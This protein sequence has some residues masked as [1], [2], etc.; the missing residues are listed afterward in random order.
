VAAVVYAARFVPERWERLAAAAAVVL[1]MP[2]FWLYDATMLLV[3]LAS[4][5]PIGSR[6]TPSL[7][8]TARAAVSAVRSLR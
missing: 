5:R 2:R 7:V 8:L 1:G 6:S 3:G 4:P